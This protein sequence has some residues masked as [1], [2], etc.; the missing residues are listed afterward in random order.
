[1]RRKEAKVS[2][3]KIKKKETELELRSKER[4]QKPSKKQ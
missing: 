3:K 1:M 2:K 4:N